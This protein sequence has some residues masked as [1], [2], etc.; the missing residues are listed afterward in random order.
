MEEARFGRKSYFRKI[1]EGLEAVAA[2]KDPNKE[3]LFLSS[4]HGH[5]DEE[6]QKLVEERSEGSESN[7]GD[8]EMVEV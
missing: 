5:E 4:G 2:D 6:A 3:K 8:E 7:D 1:R